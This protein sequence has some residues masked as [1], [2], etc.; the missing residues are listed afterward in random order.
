M[1]V[2]GRIDADLRQRFDREGPAQARE[3]GRTGSRQ[4]RDE[5]F[6][7]FFVQCGDKIGLDRC[8]RQ[9]DLILTHR[10]READTGGSDH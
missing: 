4:R 7:A 3:N 9:N 8:L 1:G 2:L 6:G 10:Q 5:P